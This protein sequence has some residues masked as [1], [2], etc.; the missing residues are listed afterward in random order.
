MFD[1]AISLYEYNTISLKT[2]KNI[3]VNTLNFSGTNVEE[4]T[5]IAWSICEELLMSEAYT[6]LTTHFMYLTKLEDLYYNVIK[7]LFNAFLILRL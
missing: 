6:F 7:Y 1:Y 5:S 3:L 2:Y 4:G